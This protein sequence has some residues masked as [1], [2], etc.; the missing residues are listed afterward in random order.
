MEHKQ[1]IP[2]ATPSSASPEKPVQ[3]SW[4]G[5]LYVCVAVCFFSTTAVFI[6]WSQPFN[7]IEIAFWRLALAAILVVVMGLITHTRLLLKRQE[8]PR[9]LLY[10]LI[11]ALH[12][13]F[14]IASLS[15]TSIAHAL[16]IV[17]TSPIFVTL[18]S[19]IFLR[20]PLARR[21]YLGIGVAIIGVAIMAGFQPHYTACNLNS[22]GHCMVLG[23]GLALFSAICLGVY[24]VIG[25]SERDRHPHFR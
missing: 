1:E 24:S 9:F 15:F 17:Y 5:L 12:F 6:R 18:L 16:A 21:K 25:R 13:I 23:D 10:G 20:E 14:Y 2:I 11:T 22:T 8:V 3:Q 4:H 19:T 7:S